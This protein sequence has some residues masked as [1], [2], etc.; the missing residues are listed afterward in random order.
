MTYFKVIQD[1]KVVSV[2][3]V[4]LKWNIKRQRLFIC[5]ANDGEFVQSYDEKHI[6]HDSWLRPAP[7]EAGQHEEASVVIISSQ[8]YEDLLTILNEGETVDYE[9]PVVPKEPEE[10]TQP[11]E[12]KPLTIAEMREIISRQQ[13]QIEM[14]I[15]KLS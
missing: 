4:F 13:E 7:V 14:L 9:T 12:E 10:I 8:E 2:G 3:T 6:Y 11:T 15:Q 5:D 1:N